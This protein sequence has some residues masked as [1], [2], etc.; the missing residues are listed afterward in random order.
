[1]SGFLRN[2]LNFIMNSDLYL[3]HHYQIY[4]E[5]PAKYTVKAY[6]VDFSKKRQHI[7]ST[8]GEFFEREVLC[9]TNP[10]PYRKTTM[11]SLIT[12][13]KKQVDTSELLF[14][15]IFTDSCGMASHTSSEEVIWKAYKEFFERQS[16]IANFIFHLPATKIIEAKDESV[17][18]IHHYI[19]N[20]LDQ[21]E[22]FNVSL[23]DSLYVILA[24]GWS[25][26]SK[27]VG[28][29]TS[30]NLKTAI[31]KAQKEIM[32]YYAVDVSKTKRKEAP[33][34]VTIKKDAY[35]Q[36]FDSLSV[37]EIL[38]L[39]GYLKNS[40][41]VLFSEEIKNNH[42]LGKYEI[43]NDNY[44]KLKINPYIAVFNGREEIGVKVVKIRDFNWFPHMRPELYKVETITNLE[45]AFG[46]KRKNFDNWL[47]F[48]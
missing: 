22:Y 40:K 19:H 7:R 16:F 18:K 29:G 27:A 10:F 24:I 17:L 23:N 21:I 34:E 28:I 1:M 32:Q 20:Y 47:P 26:N 42:K 6:E 2:R 48:I 38:S 30:R 33:E 46:W 14:N 8:I 37:K 45:K 11:V 4:M 31:E 12:G 9:N 5:K 36:Y 13:E 15:G 25:N 39:Y 44:E 35:H 3:L 43:I 41:E